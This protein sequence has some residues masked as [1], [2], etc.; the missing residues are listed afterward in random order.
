MWLVLLKKGACSGKPVTNF[1]LHDV[2]Y[3]GQLSRT[4]EKFVKFWSRILPFTYVF[5]P[6]TFY[7]YRKSG[8]GFVLQLFYTLLSDFSK[9]N[10]IV[11]CE[12]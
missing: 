10:D 2:Q 7:G 8:S 3:T 12:Q 4:F 9:K 6:I 11:T 5:A 1:P